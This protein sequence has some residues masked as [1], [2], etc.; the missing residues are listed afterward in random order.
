MWDAEGR[1]LR[2]LMTL[3]RRGTLVRLAKRDFA[4]FCA[5]GHDRPHLMKHKNVPI[6]H[7]GHEKFV[8][9]MAGCHGPI[10][11]GITYCYMGL[12]DFLFAVTIKIGG[13][14]ITTTARRLW[15]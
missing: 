13:G 2:C 6:L 9:G 15:P 1:T 4:S 5:L 14:W 7:E 3:I 12:S 8:G 11:G 10:S